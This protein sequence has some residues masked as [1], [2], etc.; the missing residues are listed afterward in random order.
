[1]SVDLVRDIAAGTNPTPSFADG[2]QVQRVLAAVETS[3]ES[4]SWQEI[5]A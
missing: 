3:S 2:L 1:M 4:D 5:P